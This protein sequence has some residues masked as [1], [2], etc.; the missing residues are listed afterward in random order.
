MPRYIFW[1]GFCAFVSY[2]LANKANAI[3]GAGSLT[4]VLG[5]GGMIGLSL[6]LATS[7][8]PSVAFAA[9]IIMGFAWTL[10]ATCVYFFTFRKA[11]YGPN[12]E[13]IALGIFFAIPAP[14]IWIIRTS[15]V[16]PP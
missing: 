2:A 4:M 10:L 11:S 8:R 3:V 12:W 13:I 7:T 1:I 6:A 16:Q 14:V 15:R 5:Y 9:K